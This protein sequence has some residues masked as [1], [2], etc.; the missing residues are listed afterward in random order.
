MKR[1]IFAA[2]L[3]LGLF[4][5]L[6]PARADHYGKVKWVKDVQTGFLTA[7][8]SGKPMMLFFSAAW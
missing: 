6:S 7:K 2:A 3:T 8:K 1:K 5:G 4:T